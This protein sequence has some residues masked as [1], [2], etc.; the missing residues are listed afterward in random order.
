MTIGLAQTKLD[1][2]PPAAKTLIAEAHDDAKA[3]LVELRNVVRGIAPTI[4]SDRGLDAALSAVVQRAET[5][6]VPTTLHLE[7][8]RRLPDEVESVAYFVVAEA[9]TNVAKHAG[10]T[11]AVVTVRLDGSANLLHISIFDDGRGG[12]SIST[13]ENATGLRGL[14]ER[15]RAAGGTFGVSSP[16]TG[17]TIVTAVLPCGS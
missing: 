3:A 16:A 11:Q 15:V 13:D 14:Q 6:G 1:S 2:D 8:P 4:L 17:P 7:L 9:L 12:A 5:S 10:A